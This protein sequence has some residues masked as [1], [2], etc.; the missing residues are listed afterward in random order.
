MTKKRKKLCLMLN[1]AILIIGLVIN[2][3]V[4]IY[5]RHQELSIET[6]MLNYDPNTASGLDI[7]TIIH[8]AQKNIVQINVDTGQSDRIGSGFLYNTRGDIITNAHVIE[9]AKTIHVTMSNTE[10]YPA[11]IVGISENRDI[12]VIR[13]P[14][15]M[16]QTPIELD[17]SKQLLVG[18]EIIAVGSPLGFQ[19]SVSIG[20]ISGID[21]SF[22]INAYSYE[23]VYQ[24]S[25]NITHGNSG[26]PL[27]DRET[28]K[29]VGI[30]S[31]GIE[32]S[33]IGFSIPIYSVIDEITE[34]STSVSNAQLTFPNT[35]TRSN[36]NL[37]KF[38]EDAIYL[39]QYF[40][41]S[42]AIHDYINAYALIGSELQGEMDYPNFRS[43][44]LQI[45]NISMTD[46]EVVEMT[47]Q[48]ANFQ[49]TVELQTTD[50]GEPEQVLVNFQ[51]G[52]E[53]D[54]L[55]ILQYEQNQNH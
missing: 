27:I 13:V 12:A 14:Q 53:N 48:M 36:Q 15:L 6:D 37:D 9:D 54:Q 26:G 30:N 32:D 35:M 22:D 40:I 16:N 38:E 52:Y 8:E 46:Y 17:T 21:R 4:Y 39:M 49:S 11:A 51:I 23:N 34:W 50:A 7:Q 5:Y 55:K 31:A 19:N 24:I 41:E 43:R 28:G 45:R 25:A 20:I 47:N 44:Y 10:T 18:S 1:L 33:E 3:R 2:Y 42:I 29:V